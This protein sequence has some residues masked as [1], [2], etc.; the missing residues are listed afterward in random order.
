MKRVVFGAHP[1]GPLGIGR[2]GGGGGASA[3]A[4]HNVPNDKRQARRA[5]NKH[6]PNA[7]TVV[8]AVVAVVVFAAIV[9]ITVVIITAVTVQYS[10]RIRGCDQPHCG[11]V[12][13][14]AHG[15]TAYAETQTATIRLWWRVATILLAINKCLH[16][17]RTD[18]IAPAT[19]MNR[20][21]SA[22]HDRETL[23][24]PQRQWPNKSCNRDGQSA[25]RRSTHA[26]ATAAVETTWR[27]RRLT[28]PRAQ[29]YNGQAI[30]NA[31][32]ATPST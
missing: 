16:C 6:A 7:Q 18:N 20:A 28:K 13:G 4:K 3:S 27:P 11:D 26:R 1:Y 2:V 15:N 25:L 5:K 31:A 32:G 9:S 29:T 24:G 10:H 12:E 14:D 22:K 23:R 19:G 30:F 21:T 8:T 17:P